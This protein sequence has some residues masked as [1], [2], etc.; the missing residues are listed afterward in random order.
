MLYLIFD[1]FFVESRTRCTQDTDC[2][3]NSFC[4]DN[5][6]TKVGRCKCMLGFEMLQRNQTFYSCLKRK[7]IVYLFFF[8]LKTN[9]SCWEKFRFPSFVKCQW[10]VT[11]SSCFSQFFTGKFS[12]K[13]WIDSEGEVKTGNLIKGLFSQLVIR[14]LDTSLVTSQKTS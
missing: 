11:F 3:E 7:W 5:D 9:K 8:S 13:P 12:G 10:Y 1:F 2:L 4:F 14:E 6:N